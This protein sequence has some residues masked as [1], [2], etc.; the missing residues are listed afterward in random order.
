MLNFLKSLVNAQVLDVEAKLFPSPGCTFGGKCEVELEVFHAGNA[1][2][3]IEIKHTGIPDGTPVEVVAGGMTI[4]T[5]Q[6]VGGFAKEYLEYAE[7]QVHPELAVGDLVEMRIAGQ[8]CY[9]GTCRKD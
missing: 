9:S 1:R 7:H 5:V 3:E 8:T 2:M 4:A 6:P